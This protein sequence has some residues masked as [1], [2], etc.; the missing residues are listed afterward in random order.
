M[1]D[2]PSVYQCYWRLRLLSISR[3]M[4][5][6][7]PSTGHAP[8]DTWMLYNYSCLWGPAPTSWRSVPKYLYCRRNRFTF[9]VAMFLLTLPL[10][11]YLRTKAFKK[12][13]VEKA[14]YEAIIGPV[15]RK[16]IL[17]LFRLMVSVS[18][19]WTM[20]SLANTKTSPSSSSSKE[21]SPSL[22]FESWQP[23]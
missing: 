2:S 17:N 6:S 8:Q 1:V 7:L 13:G 22:V 10:I 21:L 11:G 4:R 5:G 3:T 18:L 15:T 12:L 19:P 14:G 23:S 16:L 20:P 9:N